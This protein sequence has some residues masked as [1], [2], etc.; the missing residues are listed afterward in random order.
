MRIFVNQLMMECQ[1]DVWWWFLPREILQG[2]D[3]VYQINQYGYHYQ[4]II[5][6]GAHGS[7]W[8]SN[9]FG[10]EEIVTKK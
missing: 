6:I 1:Y 10:Y 4:T 5:G 8:L 2:N 9:P 3:K 7:V